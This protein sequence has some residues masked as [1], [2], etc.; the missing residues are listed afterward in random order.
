MVARSGGRVIG[1]G[2]AIGL[3]AAALL[4]RTIASVLFG[5]Q[6]LDPVTYVAVATL[7]GVTAVVAT[8]V[9]AMRAARSIRNRWLSGSRSGS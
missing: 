5:V 9:P 4:G 8:A 6:P 3:V 2:V 7:L 1:I